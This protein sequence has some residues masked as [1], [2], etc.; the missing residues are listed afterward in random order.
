M[1]GDGPPE[2]MS[3]DSHSQEV[4]RRRLRSSLIA[5]VLIAAAVGGIVGLIG[6]RSA[7]VIAAVVVA[8]PLLYVSVWYSR[9]QLWLEGSDLVVRT[10]GK[11]RIALGSVERLQLFV[12]E[13]GNARTIGLLI[14][15]EQGGGV[16][17]DL[18]RYAGTDRKEL[19]VFELR[20]LA[21]AVAPNERAGGAIFSDLLVGQLRS[22]A[23]GDPDELRPLYRLAAAAPSGKI[24]QSYST[25]A[26]ARFVSTLD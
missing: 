3:L 5:I 21:D 26:I 25:D 12:T 4:S 17:I 23:K 8:A 1:S 7:G 9:R 22:I 18:G 19:D 20:R 16:K 6:N 14:R 15:P 10:W 24:A 13:V 11:R 2:R